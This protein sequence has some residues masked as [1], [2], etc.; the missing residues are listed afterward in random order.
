MWFP[1]ATQCHGTFLLGCNR[2]SGRNSA[3]TEFL[4]EIGSCTIRDSRVERGHFMP[5]NA[6]LL[7]AR[8][9]GVKVCNRQ[10]HILHV[11]NCRAVVVRGCVWGGIWIGVFDCLPGRL[12]EKL[13][14]NERPVVI[15]IAFKRISFSI[16]WVVRIGH[17]VARI[18]PGERGDLSDVK[19]DLEQLVVRLCILQVAILLAMRTQVAYTQIDGD[20]L[21][22]AD[23]LNV[24]FPHL[25]VTV[26]CGI[27]S[28]FIHFSFSTQWFS[29][30][31]DSKLC[32]TLHRDRAHT[33]IFCH[34]AYGVCQL[35]SKEVW[36]VP[37]DKIALVVGFLAD[38][39]ALEN[40][41]V[42]RVSILLAALYKDQ[43]QHRDH[44]AVSLFFRQ[45]SLPRPPLKRHTVDALSEPLTS[46]SLSARKDATRL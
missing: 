12:V 28:S 22:I 31:F 9:S 39:R 41:R 8:A 34:C 16:R 44:L 7:E 27:G 24:D 6:I 40:I 32:S 2:N 29:I 11:P 17:V 45:G 4:S 18:T 46:L 13:K 20:S 36:R 15:S 21:V 10:E 43:K 23:I 25:I 26:D 35:R 42:Q 38:V 37:I 19:T 5:L 33:R 1:D 3:L 14:L 30:V